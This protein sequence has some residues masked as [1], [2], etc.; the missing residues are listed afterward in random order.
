MYIHVHDFFPPRTESSQATRN[1]SHAGGWSACT[2]ACRN[3]SLTFIDLEFG[4]GG[5][6]TVCRAR[7][8]AFLGQLEGNGPVLFLAVLF[9]GITVSTKASGYPNR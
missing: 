6:S 8:I 5:P 1:R 3:D 7:S 9:I 2:A 4:P